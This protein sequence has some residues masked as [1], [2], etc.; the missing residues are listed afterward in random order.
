MAKYEDY[1]PESPKKKKFRLFEAGEAPLPATE[2]QAGADE[3]GKEVLSPAEPRFCLRCPGVAL[4]LRSRELIEVYS[5]ARSECAAALDAQI[6]VCPECRRIELR[7]PEDVDLPE[8]AVEGEEKYMR[9]L[10]GMSEKELRSVANSSLRGE[11][12]RA[13]ARKLLEEGQ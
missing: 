1:A 5:A 11:E 6:W 12:I 8:E 4:R 3:A 10:R 7:W 2:E 9:Q 13:A